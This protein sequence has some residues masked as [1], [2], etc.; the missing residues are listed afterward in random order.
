MDSSQPATA[1]Y[2]TLEHRCG[3]ENCRTRRYRRDETDGHMYCRYGHQQPDAFET[4]IEDQEQFQG[5]SIRTTKRRKDDGEEGA[6][7]V[8]EKKRRRFLEGR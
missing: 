5:A 1:G 3:I 6:G 2:I 8:E 4:Q 7:V